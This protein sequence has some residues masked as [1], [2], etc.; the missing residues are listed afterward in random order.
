MAIVT[1]TDT[2]AAVPV[3]SAH[4]VNNL[5]RRLRA[6]AKAARPRSARRAYLRLFGLIKAHQASAAGVDGRMHDVGALVRWGSR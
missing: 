5:T 2:G 4:D 6:Q 3:L 1:S